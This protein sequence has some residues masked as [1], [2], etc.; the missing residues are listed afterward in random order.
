MFELYAITTALSPITHMSGVSGN[1][2]LL[3]RE[4]IITDE[5]TA[6]QVPCISGNALRHAL[7]R[8]PAASY[9][10]KT[11]GLK[12]TSYQMADFLWHGGKLTKA[13]PISCAKVKE[14]MSMIPSVALL[15]GALPGQIL[16]GAL[17]VSRAILVCK[18]TACIISS[19]TGFDVKPTMGAEYFVSP[20]LYTRSCVSNDPDAVSDRMIYEGETVCAGSKFFHKFSIESEDPL[21]IGCLIHSLLSSS[22]SIGG[23]GRIGHGELAFE[24]SAK[25]VKIKDLQKFVSL[26]TSH[27]T[28]NIDNIKNIL[29]DIFGNGETVIK[30]TKKAS[31]KT[32]HDAMEG[33]F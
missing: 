9:L 16:E 6:C 25:D 23:M 1:A 2:A 24:W 13:S 17:K 19:M 22:R 29:F 15:G 8:S 10:Y 18:E 32:D 33:L 30:K 14:L 21:V 3:K 28:S 20:Y 5:G 26:Y 4:Q 27:L 12:D 7:V 11:A 31:K